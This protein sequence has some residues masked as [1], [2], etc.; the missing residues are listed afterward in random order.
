DFEVFDAQGLPLMD[1]IVLLARRD[2]RR[3]GMAFGTLVARMIKGAALPPLEAGLLE[4]EMRAIG[5][6]ARLYRAM[7]LCCW[8]NHLRLRR[9]SWLVRSPEWLH[10]TLHAV[11]ES[12]RSIL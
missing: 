7:A 8:L 5:A 6:D 4:A 2:I 1:L 3:Q 12:V 10:E 9:D 11:V